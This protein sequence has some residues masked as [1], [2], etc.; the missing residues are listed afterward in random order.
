MG[1]EEGNPDLMEK[2]QAKIEENFKELK[3]KNKRM[4]SIKYREKS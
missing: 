3:E 2:L 4:W 1:S